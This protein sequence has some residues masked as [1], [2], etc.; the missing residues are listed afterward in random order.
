MSGTETVETLVRLMDEQCPGLCWGIAFGAAA[1]GHPDEERAIIR[2]VPTR[3]TEFRLGRMAARQALARL[4]VQAPVPMGPGR[5]PIWPEGIAGSITHHDGIAVAV[6][7]MG[8][9]LGLDLDRAGPLDPDLIP[10][11]CR[12][13]ENASKARHIFSAKEAAYKAQYPANRVVF[14]FHGLSVDLNRGTATWP[15]HPETA[16]IAPDSRPPL[17]ICQLARDGWL[18]SLTYL[19]D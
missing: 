17:P 10:E 6:V 18:L 3:Q 13:E 8:G 1:P 4:G 11:I 19:P 5:A 12:P 16:T 7:T 9:W 2:A 15:E 14:G